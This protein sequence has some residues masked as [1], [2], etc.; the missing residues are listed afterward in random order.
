MALETYPYDT[1][2]YLTDAESIFFYLEAELEEN[3]M[4]YLARALTTVARARG[5]MDI[6]ATDT[7]LAV[8]LLE[9]AAQEVGA[10]DRDALIKV[11]EAYRK[12]MSSDSRVA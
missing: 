8:D 1:A 10:G 12:R 11:M 2:D 4:P 9:R 7:G 6:V 5:G 3:E